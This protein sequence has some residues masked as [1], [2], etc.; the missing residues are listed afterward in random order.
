MNRPDLEYFDGQMS[1]F[2]ETDKTV[3]NL[4]SNVVV[5]VMYRMSNTCMEILND[6]MSDIM[7]IVQRE[8][9]ICY[10]LGDLNVDLLKH[11]NHQSTTVLI[12]ISLPMTYLHSRRILLKIIW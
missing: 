7:K 8:R 6:R 4:S 12:F 9:K 5:G 2:I 11:E 3:F 10:F 1:L